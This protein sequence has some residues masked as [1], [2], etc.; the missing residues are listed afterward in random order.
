MCACTDK[1]IAMI[2]KEE[3]MNFREG[4]R[5]DTRQDKGREHTEDVCV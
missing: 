5:N 1:N 2:I 3:I 4:G